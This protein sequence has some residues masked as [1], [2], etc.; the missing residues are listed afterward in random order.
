VLSSIYQARLG[1]A[2]VPAPV[3]GVARSSVAAGVTVARRI[4]SAALLAS[5]RSAFVDGLD[6]M[7]WTC[8]GIALAS[9]LQALAFL[10]RR[11]RG[12]A[13]GQQEP[14]PAG[15]GETSSERAELGI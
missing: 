2:A 14:V 1:S 3:A 10:P 9:A 12:G 15:S 13:A 4:G 8:G 6:V 11:A 5:V 7:L